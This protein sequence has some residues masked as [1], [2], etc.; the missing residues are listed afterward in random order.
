MA[1]T[2]DFDSYPITFSIAAVE[3]QSR[4]VT[5]TWSDGRVSRFHNIWLR[6]N[7]PCPG[8]VHQ[9]TKEQTFELVAVAPDIRPTAAT[10]GPDGSLLVSW[11]DL[12]DSEFHAGWLRAHDYGDDAR[13]ERA[14]VTETWDATLG[15]PPTFDAPSVLVDDDALYEWLQAFEQFGMTRLRN[16]AVNE[17]AL[18]QLAARVGIVRDTNFGI[19]WDVWSETNPVTNANT[20][21]PLPPHVDLPTREY[22]PGVQFLHCLENEAL[23]GDSIVLDGFRLAEQLRAESADDYEI[24][25]TV[26]WNWANRATSTDHRWTSPLLVTGRDGSLLEVRVGNWLRA[27]LD[28]AFD[29]VEAAYAAYRRLF[30]MTYR[31][32]LQLRFRLEPGDVNVFD[33]RRILHARSEFTDV[34]G[35]R[36]LRGCYSERDEVRSRLRILERAKRADLVASTP[37]AASAL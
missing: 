10:V 3:P 22:Q 5:V 35:R 8:C 32:D 30:E 37:S 17:D 24:L 27:P 31:L 33:N 9:V 20:A 2:P 21:L 13:A 28:L 6:D 23:G 29:E 19:F 34:G 1:L 18:P 4:C 7:C 16:L 25:T 26:P 11:P 15:E 12:H 36:H 14:R